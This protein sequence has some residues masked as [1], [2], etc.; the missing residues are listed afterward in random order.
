MLFQDIDQ[1]G[2]FIPENAQIRSG[3]LIKW[4]FDD[5]CSPPS[6]HG[7]ESTVDAPPPRLHIKKN[8]VII[9]I[10]YFKSI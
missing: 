2:R 6:P 3:K 4:D 10:I 8:S 9:I 1:R 7:N 5:A